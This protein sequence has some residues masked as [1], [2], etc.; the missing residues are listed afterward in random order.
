MKG[1]A[2]SA[3]GDRYRSP[4]VR[5]DLLDN[6][7]YFLNDKEQEFV[8]TT[9]MKEVT[10]TDTSSGTAYHFVH[11]SSM[12]LSPGKK[13]WYQVL[14]KG[15]VPLYRY[16]TKILN[17]TMPYG[18]SVS[19]QKITTSEEF[20]IGY[21]GALHSTRKLKDVPAILSNK[22]GELEKYMDADVMKTGTTAEKMTALVTYYNSLL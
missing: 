11:A 16:F 22:R 12:P 8:C 15:K 5:L 3:N 13:G 4:K 19:E 2:L 20:L 1:V 18:S 21:N 7:L 14:V 17:E 9:P 10:L 6:Q